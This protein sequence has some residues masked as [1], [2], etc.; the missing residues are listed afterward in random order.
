L[1]LT[2]IR[3]L[4]LWPVVFWAVIAFQLTVL[5]DTLGIPAMSR[6]V[7]VLLLALLFTCAVTTLTG[8][9]SERVTVFYCLPIALVLAG[10]FV[11]ILLS[12]NLDAFGYLGLAVPW[13]AALSV[14]FS[15]NFDPDRYWR[16]F[17]RFMIVASIIAVVEYTAVFYGYL[18]P[19]DIKTKRG[20]FLKGVFTI[21]YA[22]DDPNTPIQ[23]RMYG[24]F[25]EPGAFCMYLLPAIAYAAFRRSWLAVVLFVVSMVYTLSIGGFIGLA[26]LA[27]FF[28]HR[29]SQRKG[30]VVS[31][32]VVV[33]TVL[34]LTASAGVLYSFFQDVELYKGDSAADREDNLRMFFSSHI[35]EV[36]GR[37]P[38]GMDLHGESLS[39]AGE[40]DRLYMGSNFAPGTALVIGGVSAL[41]GYLVFL[42]VNT[43][44]WVR[45]LTHKTRGMVFDC[46]YVSYP[47]LLT[48]VF[49]RATVFDSA[50]YAFLFAAPM[51]SLLKGTEAATR[52][53]PLQLAQD[54]A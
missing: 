53:D 5:P 50:F 11:N 54:E 15:R 4:R 10:Y 33:V 36:I 3:Y 40:G 41:V 1:A 25:A 24:V 16:Y 47:A 28:V 44:C 13:L 34:V 27:V 39:A 35:V 20:D 26:I 2:G 29:L 12:A 51:L 9:R 43:V 8:M 14:P 31:T 42:A 6:V 32:I 48:F 18:E 22:G 21:F 49:Q 45:L 37:A 30:P 7:N 19:T 17:Y 52:A 23:E 46:V 38:L